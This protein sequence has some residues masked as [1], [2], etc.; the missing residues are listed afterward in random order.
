MLTDEVLLS[1]SPAALRTLLAIRHCLGSKKPVEATMETL[2]ALTGYKRQNLS[3]GL[4][5]LKERGLIE[6]TRTKRNLGKYHYN[7][8]SL[9]G[10][11]Q[12]TLPP[13]PCTPQDTLVEEP[14]TLED[15]STADSN[16][17]NSYSDTTIDKAYLTSNRKLKYKE[18][19]IVKRWQGD[20]DDGIAGFGLFGDEKPAAEKKKLS[21]DKRDPKTRK[22]RPQDEWTPNDVAAEFRDQLTKL[23]PYM[24]PL[25]NTKNLAGAL[26]KYRK[27]SG[28]TAIVELEL[29]R[30]FVEDPRNHADWEKGEMY[31]YLY[32]RFLNS[33]K[34]LMPTALK[35]LGITTDTVPEEMK[36]RTDV[37]YAS[38]GREFANTIPGRKMLERHEQRLRENAK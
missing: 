5:E 16:S 15:T 2:E 20:E 28:I 18:F 12:D 37:M 36:I 33:F 27:D 11:P 13:E 30:L 31:Q 23:Y 38:D 26:A 10:I 8:Y 35:N 7:R 34:T 14:C 4:V 6:V 24:P 25:V 32:K 17:S 1:L 29:L 19:P 9:P 22:R 21:T 3:K